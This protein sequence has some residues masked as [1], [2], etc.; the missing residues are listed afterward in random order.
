MDG[1]PVNI[2]DTSIEDQF[3]LDNFDG[4]N[5]LDLPSPSINPRSIS[6][7]GGLSQGQN[8]NHAATRRQ[9]AWAMAPTSHH[10]HRVTMKPPQRATQ[11]RSIP[12]KS[13]SNSGG[14]D[15]SALGQEMR[16]AAQRVRTFGGQWRDIE[17]YLDP[18]LHQE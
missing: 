2:F 17:K 13:T 7:H 1:E 15:A 14:K 16:S 8:Q 12:M 10:D 4:D 3:V 5:T 18:H 6:N 9:S 11:A